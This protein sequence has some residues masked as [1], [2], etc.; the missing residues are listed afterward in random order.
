M[1]DKELL[2]REYIEQDNDTELTQSEEDEEQVKAKETIEKLKAL[3]TDKKETA[4]QATKRYQQALQCLIELDKNNYGYLANYPE[5]FQKITAKELQDEEKRLNITLPKE[6]KDFV[7]KHGLIRYDETVREMVFP[8]KTLSEALKDEWGMS[9]ESIDEAYEGVTHPDELIVFSYGD[10]GLQSEYYHCF[11]KDGTVYDFNQDDLG[12]ERQS[13]TNFDE[14]LQW[15]TNTLIEETIENLRDEFGIEPSEEELYKLDEVIDFLKTEVYGKLD[16]TDK[17]V[18]V[19]VHRDYLYSLPD[20]YLFDLELI[21]LKDYKSVLKTYEETYKEFENKETLPF[22][23]TQ[24]EG[25]FCIGYEKNNGFKRMYYFDPDFCNMY[26]VRDVF[27]FYDTL[28][29]IKG[30]SLSEIFEEE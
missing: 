19:S 17:M 15:A 25:V 21:D 22:L 13:H 28:I 1:I 30:K 20:K 8:L 4:E 5:F 16:F 9:D 18:D 10:Q 3:L 14:Y 26:I 27:E 11:E 6:Y 29:D 23:R 12:Y 7:L 24:G 2:S